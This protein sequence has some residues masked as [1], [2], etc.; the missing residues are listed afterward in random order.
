M[1]DRDTWNSYDQTVDGKKVICIGEKPSMR[2]NPKK[3][4]YYFCIEGKRAVYYRRGRG[5]PQLIP[6]AR[7]PQNMEMY[8][9]TFVEDPITPEDQAYFD[10]YGVKLY[11]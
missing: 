9:Q 7:R 1:V 10:L 6:M 2:R 11:A 3:T 4:Q 5:G 8:Y